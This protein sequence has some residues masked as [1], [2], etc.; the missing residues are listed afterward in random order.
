M[1]ATSRLFLNE[2]TYLSGVAAGMDVEDVCAQ[3]KVVIELDDDHI[4]S[5]GNLL[6]HQNILHVSP[7]LFNIP[8]QVS[9]QSVTLPFV[10]D[11]LASGCFLGH[12]NSFVGVPRSVLQVLCK[13][14]NIKANTKNDDMRQ[15]LS[16]RSQTDNKVMVALQ[17]ALEANSVSKRLKSE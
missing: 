7:S 15:A 4:K 11:T 12:V 6:I 5:T 8:V 10:S 14:F 17:D 13:E 1:P 9:D 16:L 3:P 2:T